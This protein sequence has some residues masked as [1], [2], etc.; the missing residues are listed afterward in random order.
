MPLGQAQTRKFNIGT[1]ELRVGPLSSAMRLVQ[2]HSIGLVDKVMVSVTQDKVD[3]E[4]M[5]PKVVVD[6]AI[7]SQK[8]EIT[9]T[10]REYSR[11]NMSLMLGNGIAPV[12]VNGLPDPAADIATTLSVAA[13]AAD[14]DLTVV[15]AGALAAGDFI[16]VYDVDHPENVEVL[17]IASVLANVITLDADTP[18]VM[19]HPSGSKVFAA[20][21]VAVGA[22]TQTEYF[23][24]MIVQKQNSNG[25]PV[26]MNFWKVT[27]SAGMEYGSDPSN[28]ASTDIK[29]T[30]L[31]PVAVDYAVGAPLEHLAN[32]IPAHPM[33]M[34]AGGSDLA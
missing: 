22:I 2:A 11:R 3:L 17:K 16:I 10:A 19:A 18:V 13:V 1:A 21:Q 28:F 8:A 5:F 32:I 14:T 4:G 33:G 15:A 25:R 27:N 29:L 30:C 12:D 24:A 26:V 31:T 9:A 34:I 20:R 6:S 7:I 23:S